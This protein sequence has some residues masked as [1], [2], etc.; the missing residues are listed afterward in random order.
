MP[1][2]RSFSRSSVAPRRPRTNPRAPPARSSRAP[3][4]AP[5]R[6]GGSRLIGLT[7]SPGG[8]KSSLADRMVEAYRA[9]GLRV[10]VIAVDPTSP[11]SGGAILGDRIRMTRWHGDSE[12]F[13]RSMATRGQLGG[14]AAATLRIA[15]LLD[16]AG[17]D[18]VLIETVG[19]GQ[20]EV[21]VAA[22]ADSTVL[23]MTPA[24]G[25]AV[26]AFKAGVMEVADLFVIN[27]ADLPGA[28]RL[29]RDVR[30]VQALA[31]TDADAWTAPVVQTRAS[32]GTGVQ[33]V[34][35]ALDQHADW[36][37][38]RGG[39]ARIRRGRVRAELAA[40]VRRHA[41]MALQLGTEARLHD[42]AEGRATAEEVAAELLRAWSARADASGD[43]VRSET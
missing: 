6:S 40:A 29:Q 19:V 2:R 7:G 43:T 17:Y 41:A 38:A 12:V 37:A 4:R 42:I 20:S 25:D 11:Y 33:E 10:A 31:E 8:G 22:V 28:E 30:A 27:K 36:L 35:S 16:A 15:A 34:L 3:S 5:S 9:H 39:H 23:V 21:D 14:L 26:Q 1:G 18:R 32:D 24:G 13:V